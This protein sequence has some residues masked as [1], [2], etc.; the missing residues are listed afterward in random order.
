MSGEYEANIVK[1]S[2][3]E[4]KKTIDN[5]GFDIEQLNE[6]LPEHK[7]MDSI[8]IRL[9]IDKLRKRLD[10]IEK[11]NNACEIICKD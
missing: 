2:R 6:Y 7:R 8:N 10:Y 1:Y 9:N 11:I 4:I 5:M 3:D